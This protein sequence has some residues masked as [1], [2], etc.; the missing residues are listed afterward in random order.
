MVHGKGCNTI[1]NALHNFILYLRRSPSS[2]QRGSA[3]FTAML[4]GDP[5]TPGWAATKDAPRNKSIGVPNIPSLPISY[6]DALPLLKAVEY[7]GVCDSG[8]WQG[9]LNSITYCS[10]PSEGQVHL[11]NTVEYKHT[12]IWNVIGHIQGKEEA[13]HA[14]I[15]GKS[16]KLI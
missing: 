11:I 9:G 10:G 1:N 8:D 3:Q 13:D 15:L 2:V 5:S 14:V 16:R 7:R 6:N 4:A 12:P